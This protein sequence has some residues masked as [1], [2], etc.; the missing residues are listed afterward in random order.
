[1]STIPKINCIFKVC[2]GLF[3]VASLKTEQRV[4]FPLQIQRCFLISAKVQG[5]TGL[6]EVSGRQG[7]ILKSCPKGGEGQLGIRRPE[8]WGPH[9]CRDGFRRPLASRYPKCYDKSIAQW[10]LLL[11]LSPRSV[12]SLLSLADP[13]LGFPA[14]FPISR[15]MLP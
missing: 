15:T 14:T 5:S 8:V 11:L 3:R 6:V 13:P 2:F 4:E 12:C 1:M 10:K 7:R 9:G